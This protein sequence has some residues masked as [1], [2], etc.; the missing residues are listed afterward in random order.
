M[1]A[2]NTPKQL[3]G[4]IG[5]TLLV[6]YYACSIL[7]KQSRTKNDKFYFYAIL[8]FS[9][10]AVIEAAYGIAGF[11]SDF[12]FHHKANPV[13]GSFNNPAGFAVLL[14]SIYPYFLYLAQVTKGKNRRYIY[15]SIAV[16]FIAMFMS[17]SRSGILCIISVS[18]LY[19]LYKKRIAYGKIAII[20]MIPICI[21]IYILYTINRNSANGRLFIWARSFELIKE[22]LIGGYG[23]GAFKANYMTHQANYFESNP[24]SAYSMIADNVQYPYN[25]LINLVLE[26]GLMGLLLFAIFII[27][28][29]LCYR[30][31]HT[32]VKVYAAMSCLSIALF[33]LF[34]Y[35][36]FY[37]YT[38]IIVGFNLYLIVKPSYLKFD[39]LMERLHI[40][41]IF[42]FCTMIFA[43]V[44]IY[45]KIQYT[46]K[47]LKWKAVHKQYMDTRNGD[48]LLEYQLLYDDMKSNPFFL[49]N[50]AV[51]LYNQ[52]KYDESYIIA[53]QAKSLWK[54]YEIELLL[55]DIEDKRN[56][57]SKAIQHYMTASNMCPA[58]FHPLVQIQ[59]IY[60]NHGD[61]ISARKYATKIINKPEKVKSQQIKQIKELIKFELR[62][63][64]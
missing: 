9:I 22:R 48:V 13:C 40:K 53:E 61:S 58:K 52:G 1:D 42:A 45:T 30:K 5:V 28:V 26:Y 55:G 35:P 59:Q 33:S 4:E 46:H 3:F 11:V 60:K 25:E 7:L 43:S 12:M 17:A 54:N 21:L 62:D 15:I 44:L 2:Q 36:F 64:R 50:Y 39:S 29:L 8:C 63:D 47:E 10:I 18:L 49:F 56:N 24:E 27:C 41:Y 38:W 37:T 19:I 14:S 57:P 32:T 6:L 23:T 16:I 20:A 31:N 34:S 51:I